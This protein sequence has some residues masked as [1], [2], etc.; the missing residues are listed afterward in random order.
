MSER[1]RRRYGFAATALIAALAAPPVRAW[2]E[3]DMRLHMLVQFPLL[4]AAGMLAA[5]ALTP[6]ARAA[7]AAWNRHGISGLLCAALVSMFWMLPKALDDAIAEPWLDAA[8]YASLSLGVGFALAVS[9]RPA[10]LFG[11]GLFLGN[12]LPMLAVVGWLYLAAPVRL[13][14]AYLPGQQEAT[15]QLLIVAGVAGMFAW[16]ASY[17]VEREV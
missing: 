2:L 4:V 12:L 3:A 13:C 16:L 6:R 10:G 8:K 17:F 9:W 5:A 11:R 15:G 1:H 7:L 14:N